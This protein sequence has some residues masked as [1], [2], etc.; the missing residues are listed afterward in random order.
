[1]E[2]A[3]QVLAD[4]PAAQER[5]KQ[6]R[7]YLEDGDNTVDALRKAEIFPPATCRLLSLGMQSGNGDVTM[8]EIARR[9]SEDADIALSDAIAKV[10][11]TL[12]LVTSVLVGAILLSVMLPLINIME[13]IG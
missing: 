7:E 10:E 8:R 13:T 3:A 12:V 4:V 11:P 1:M 5:C 9:L 2:L 6:C